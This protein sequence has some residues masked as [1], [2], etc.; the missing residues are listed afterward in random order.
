MEAPGSGE[1]CKTARRSLDSQ[2]VSPLPQRRLIHSDDQAIVTPAPAAPRAV[3]TRRMAKT[4][5]LLSCLVVLGLPGFASAAARPALPDCARHPSRSIGS[6]GH[7]RLLGGVL[8]PA[9]GPD[10]FAW[11]FRSQQIGGSDRTR[12]GN[13]SVVRA[14]LRGIAAYRE[15]HPEAPPVAVGDMALRHG[16]PIDGHSTHQNGRQIDLY[17]PRRDRRL[18]EPHKVAQ[19]DLRL[20]RALV[21]AML[22]AGAYGVLI[23]PH[24]RMHPPRGVIRWPNHDDH[25]HAMF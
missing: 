13:C 7:G 21:Q 8:F 23:G 16:G 15:R 9:T 2:D 12:W 24:L 19:V 5:A 3:D 20:S 25:L 22:D 1:R 11:N 6:P 10:H 17:F 4:V 18:R 14:V